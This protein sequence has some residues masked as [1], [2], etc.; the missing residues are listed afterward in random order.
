VLPEPA[1][2]VQRLPG[3]MEE[4]HAA[5]FACGH[6]LANTRSRVTEM[7]L[8]LVYER[9]H[10][11]TMLIRCPLRRLRRSAVTP[12]HSGARL[13]PCLRHQRAGRERR[14]DMNVPWAPSSGRALTA[15]LVNGALWALGFVSRQRALTQ[16]GLLHAA[17]LGTLLWASLGWA[18]WTTCLL[19]L[20]ISSIA[21]RLK[22]D[23]KEQLGIAEKRG[24]ARGPE[25]VWGAAAVA[26]LCALLHVWL[27]GTGASARWKALARLGFLTSMAT[28]LGD[29]L[30]TEI[31]KAYGR[32][33]YLITTMQ[34]V[35]P[36]TEG[37]ISREG[38][39]ACAAG[40]LIL[41]LF[42]AASRLIPFQANALAICSVS[43]F[44]ATL[45]ESV[46]GATLQ[47]RYPWLS[48]EAVNVLN[49]AI[50]AMLAVIVG[51]WVL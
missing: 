1:P 22:Q 26:A 42:G 5:A 18:G 16:A 51:A 49:T 33:T 6:A 50:G 47:R 14:L 35:Q 2:E 38:T 29:T 40:I 30:A 19:F 28:K 34:E 27:P 8:A 32:K 46:I 15:V 24:G 9:V 36:G 31:G 13:T 45:I 43:A 7:E 12:G 17:A 25:N 21:T 44:S 3:L 23:R 4:S 20:V 41:T 11:A 10:T 39:I 37:A 48:N